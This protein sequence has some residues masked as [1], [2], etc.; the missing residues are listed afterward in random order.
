MATVT[1]FSDAHLADTPIDCTQLGEV[2]ERFCH[3]TR[4]TARDL[5]R[6]RLEALGYG[7]TTQVT[8]DGALSTTN[9]IAEK[10]GATRPE[11]I[12]LVGAHF[13]AFYAGADDNSSGV[14]A[15]LELARLFS[16][17]TFDRTVRFVGFDLEEMG[18]VGSTRYVGSVASNEP[19]LASIAFDCIGFTSPTQASLPGLPSPKQGDFVAVIANAASEPRAHHTRLLNEAL[20]MT[21][22]VGIV[23]PS[24]GASPIAGNLMRSD[25]APFWLA[26]REA[27]FFTDTANFR[28]PN[29]HTETDLPETLDPVFLRDTVRLAAVT[30]AY[31][32]GGP[33]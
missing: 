20:G 26:G 22:M 2:H 13:D 21:K 15:V 33:R 25:H 27:L 30:A 6:S 32:A 18:L 14:A 12:I 3:L 1:A 4:E 11:E 23:A 28:N 29:Y 9:L 24:D 17:R 10:V 16:T 8:E 7:V 19:I 31:F 5:M